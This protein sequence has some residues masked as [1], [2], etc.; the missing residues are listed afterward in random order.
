M[1]PNHGMPRSVDAKR[2]QALRRLL[3]AHPQ[4]LWVRELARR[5]GLGKSSVARYLEK[6]LRKEI[7]F[8]VMGRNKCACLKNPGK[9]AK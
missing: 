3:K 6:D 8:T 4:G 7:E 5:T 2:L 1:R 9:R